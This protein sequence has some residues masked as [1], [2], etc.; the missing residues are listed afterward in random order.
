MGK[1][2]RLLLLKEKHEKRCKRKWTVSFLNLTPTFQLMRK[3]F[4]KTNQ[5]VMI[6]KTCFYCE[7]TGKDGE[8]WYR[9]TSYAL[10]AHQECSGWDAPEGYLCDICSRKWNW[11]KVLKAHKLDILTLKFCKPF[12]SM[13]RC[14]FFQISDF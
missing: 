2:K 9:S 10:W 12:F 8:M 5:K 11:L 14:F 4:V 7:D 13:E 6:Q 1:R 3:T